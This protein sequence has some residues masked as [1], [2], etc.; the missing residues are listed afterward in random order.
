MPST[1]RPTALNPRE[2]APGAG[3]FALCLALSAALHLVAALPLVVW[4]RF[5]LPLDLI[6]DE[7]TVDGPVGNDGTFLAVPETPVQVSIY[8]ESRRSSH[9]DSSAP[10]PSPAPSA[11]PAPGGQPAGSSGGSGGEAGSPAD[12]TDGATTT[13]AEP[14]TLREGV[15][16]KPPRGKKKPCEQLDEVQ[17]LAEGRWRI[18]RDLMDW[19]ATHLGELERQA[20]VSTHRGADGKRDG[21]QIYLPRCSVFKQGGLRNGDVIHTINGRKVN[22]IP[23][24]VTTYLA[25]RNDRRLSVELTRRDGTEL[26]YVYIL[27]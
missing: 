6:G 1:V 3:V 18:E 15:A 12:A 13:V 4:D 16:G 25:V 26:T 24:G 23:Q 27:K 9:K 11:S 8:K 20:G 5:S 2:L 10:S 7:G 17:E 19:Y 22:T 21:A 14:R